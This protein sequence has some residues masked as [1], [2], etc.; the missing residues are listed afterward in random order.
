MRWKKIITSNDAVKDYEFVANSKTI[1]ASFM[2]IDVRKARTDKR[3]LPYA[4]SV[5]GDGGYYSF[6]GDNARYRTRKEL[7]AAIK[8]YKSAFNQHKKLKHVSFLP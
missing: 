6:P 3:I 1:R 2:P 5:Y 8:R 4:L 7:D